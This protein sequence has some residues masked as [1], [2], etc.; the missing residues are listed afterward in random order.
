MSSTPE[1]TLARLADVIPFSWVD[2]PGNRF[3][4][5]VQGCSFDCIA[6]HNPETIPSRCP[7]ARVASVGEIVEEIR[8]VEPYLAGIT[9]SGGEATLQHRFVQ[10][11]F[12]TVKADPQLS[13]L[14]TFVDS[15]GNAVRRVWDHLA[16]VM[17]GAMI[18]LKALDPEVH[19]QLTG[20]DNERELDSIRY[21]HELG[22]LHEVRLLLVPGYNDSALQLAR[23]GEWLT[24]LDPGLRVVVIGFRRHGVRPEYQ[25]LTEAS[26]ELLDE[27]REALVRSGL[28][29]V[30]TV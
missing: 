11:L 16:P 12:A 24:A 17:D 25:G 2:G 3:V 21:L 8:A 1:R 14:T 28:R 22:L 18:D 26:P 9:V 15:N 30:V 23:T 7:G 19:R 20:C 29:Q 10:D 5:F 4:V 27:S 13:R 6:C